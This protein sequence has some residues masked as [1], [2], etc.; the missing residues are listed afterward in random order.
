MRARRVCW[1]GRTVRLFAVRRRKRS[2]KSRLNLLN[3]QGTDA[4]GGKLDGKGNAIEA[5]AH[6]RHRGAIRRGEREIGLDQSDPLRE[7]PHE[8]Y[9]CTAWTDWPS[10][11]LFVGGTLREGTRYVC[12][13][14]TPR[15]SRLEAKIVKILAP[16]ERVVARRVQAPKRCSQLSS[17]SNNSL[18]FSSATSV[19]VSDLPGSSQL[20][21]IVATACGTRPEPRATPIPPANS[22][23]ITIGQL[24]RCLQR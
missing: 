13:P 19:W 8:S 10:E 6:A 15:A 24:E 5:A 22:V 12:S 23:L 7:E 18:A 3:R 1:R 16:G 21:R 2:S 20:S 4:R 11:R 17:R 14:A 9:P